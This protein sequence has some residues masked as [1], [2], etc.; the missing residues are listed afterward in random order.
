MGVTKMLRIIDGRRYNTD[1]AV[2]TIDVSPHI[3]YSRNDFHWEDT[4]LHRTKSGAW[5]LSG[6]GGPLTRWSRKSGQNTWT[7]GGGIQVIDAGEA[8]ELME[9]YANEQVD[10]YFPVQDA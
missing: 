8:R 9:R 10:Q 3:A 5:F 2:V 4:Y 7:N 6:K 1:T